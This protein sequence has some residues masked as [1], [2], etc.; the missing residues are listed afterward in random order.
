M[1]CLLF[2]FI[3]LISF[4][5]VLGIKNPFLFSPIKFVKGGPLW[6]GPSLRSL[7]GNDW[8]WKFFSRWL[9]KHF[10]D[11]EGPLWRLS[12]YLPSKMLRNN[13]GNSSDSKNE[14][15]STFS[16]TEHNIVAA[17]LITAGMDVYSINSYFVFE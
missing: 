7:S 1:C 17:Y 8:F 13:L 16:Q 12:W 15:G 11:I 2:L 14:D 5:L 10:V 3:L 9:L 4:S 6:K